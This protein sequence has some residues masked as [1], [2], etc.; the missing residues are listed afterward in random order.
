MAP[1]EIGLVVYKLH[2]QTLAGWATI[3]QVVRKEEGRLNPPASSCCLHHSSSG[4]QL[5]LQPNSS[6]FMASGL[7]HPLSNASSNHA[8]A[9][10]FLMSTSWLCS[11]V[12]LRTN[13]AFPPAWLAVPPPELR[14]PYI[15]ASHRGLSSRP[16]KFPSKTYSLAPQNFLLQTPSFW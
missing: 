7:P 3:L 13:R 8:S 5:W 15:H 14:A 16:L 6:A 2:L 9:P 4:G 12:C 11:F 10:P 1:H